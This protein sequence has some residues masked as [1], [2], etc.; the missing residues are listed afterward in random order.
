MLVNLTP[1]AIHLYFPN[2]TSVTVP[3]SGTVARVQE[4]TTEVA[5]GV[6]GTIRIVSI[7]Y[8][9]PE[10]VPEVDGNTYLVSALV[11]AALPHR[12]DVLSPGELVRD[13]KG[14]VIGCRALVMNSLEGAV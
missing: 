14:A 11:R 13:E 7:S 8:G 1:H 4:I 10:G 5:A 12:F 2:G 3:P 9:K 6:P